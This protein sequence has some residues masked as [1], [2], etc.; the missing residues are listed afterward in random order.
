MEKKIEYAFMKKGVEEKAVAPAEVSA[1]KLD[2]WNVT[3][4]AEVDVD[5]KMTAV[6]GKVIETPAHVIETADHVLRIIPKFDEVPPAVVIPPAAP[7]EEK[8]K[9]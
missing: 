8:A 3:G 9:K 6:T 5:G 1:H 4:T 2:G 7:V